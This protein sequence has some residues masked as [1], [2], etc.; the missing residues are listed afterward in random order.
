MLA[1]TVTPGEP[2][3]SGVEEVPDPDPN[4]GALLVR[5]R[6]LGVCGTDRE[7]AAGAY[8]EP[9]P[10]QTKLILGHEGLRERW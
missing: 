1:I 6:L 9:P 5:G 3:S 10:D 8:G 7:I 4:D 2:G